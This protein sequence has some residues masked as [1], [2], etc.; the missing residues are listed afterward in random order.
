MKELNAIEK[1]ELAEATMKAL[2]FDFSEMS[3]EEAF[4]MFHSIK[5]AVSDTLAAQME[6]RVGFANYSDITDEQ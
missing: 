5:N 3:V 2:G 6:D 1:L 4:Q